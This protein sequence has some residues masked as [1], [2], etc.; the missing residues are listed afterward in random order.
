MNEIIDYWKKEFDILLAKYDPSAAAAIEYWKKEFYTLL[1]KYEKV[2]Q[3]LELL[4][5]KKHRWKIKR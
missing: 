1:E 2:N 3:E 5:K 4:Q